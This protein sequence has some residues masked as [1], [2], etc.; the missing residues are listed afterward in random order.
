MNSLPIEQFALPVPV[1]SS[2]I[3]ISF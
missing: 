1:E 3:T 2:V